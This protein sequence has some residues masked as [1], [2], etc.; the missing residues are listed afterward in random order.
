M[1]SWMLNLFQM[2]WLKF[3]RRLRRLSLLL[4]LLFGTS[5]RGELLSVGYEKADARD[6]MYKLLTLWDSSK[7][8]DETGEG[9]S[10]QASPPLIGTPHT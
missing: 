6:D 3:E 7:I 2:M 4:L 8:L 5:Y 9:A 1:N 10:E